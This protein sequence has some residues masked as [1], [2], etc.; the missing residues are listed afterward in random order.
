MIIWISQFF[1]HADLFLQSI[2]ATNILIFIYVLTLPMNRTFRI[3][4]KLDLW[5]LT[6]LSPIFQLYRG[7][8][9]YWWR[10][11][12]CRRKPPNCRKSLTN[13]ITW[14]CIEYTSPETG[15]K[16]TTLLV[17]CSDC[18]GSCK[19]KCHTFTTTAAQHLFQ[20]NGKQKNTTVQEQ[21]HNKVSKS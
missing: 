12:E 5:C 7:G 18:T 13:F 11:P 10:K 4:F 17:I 6:P 8:Q 9:F 3:Y 14:C 1:G 19:F 20:Q 15:F 16:L 21:F 2:L